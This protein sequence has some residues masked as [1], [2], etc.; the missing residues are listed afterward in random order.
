MQPCHIIHLRTAGY[1]I[2]KLTY[3]PFL[4][5][6]L[7]NN[8]VW[9]IIRPLLDERTATRVIW[10]SDGAELRAELESAFSKADIP[11]WLG[12]GRDDCEALELLNGQLV[13]LEVLTDRFL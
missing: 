4:S 5:V 7:R 3:T 1:E 6:P 11:Q 9:R 2:V 8:A 10:L 12:G 13:D